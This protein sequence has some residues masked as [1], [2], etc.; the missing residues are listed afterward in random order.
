LTGPRFTWLALGLAAAGIAAL[1]LVAI[2]SIG[3]P[4]LSLAVA[5]AVLVLLLP[6]AAYFVFRHARAE[7]G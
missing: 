1:S 6:L 5:A 2:A 7:D 4:L 3:S